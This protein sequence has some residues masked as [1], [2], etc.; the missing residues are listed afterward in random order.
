MTIA[1]RKSTGLG[2]VTQILL[3]LDEVS[4]GEHYFEIGL[5]LREAMLIN[6]LLFNSE[7]WYN[8]SKNNINDLEV[9]DNLYCE[10]CYRHTAKLQLKVFFW[11]WEYYP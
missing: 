10:N 2:I 9:I 6:G 11:S 1:A 4:F 5:M 3:M 8:L 7:I